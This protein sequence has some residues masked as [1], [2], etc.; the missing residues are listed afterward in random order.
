MY[1]LSHSTFLLSLVFALAVAACQP[2]SSPAATPTPPLTKLRF[3]YWGSEMEK[4]AIE[5]MAAAFE[6]ANPD[7]DVEP[8]QIP[9]E[10]YIAQVT[11]MIQNGESPDVGYLT[12]RP[13]RLP[14]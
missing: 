5:Q 12:T 6:K 9:Y 7:V 14:A 2:L 4:A 1:R 13:A 10:G 8:I 3:T 11:A